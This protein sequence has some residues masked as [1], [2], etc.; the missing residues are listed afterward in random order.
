LKQLDKF[1]NLLSRTQ[2]ARRLGVHPM[3]VYKWVQDASI[4]YLRLRKRLKF[5]PEKIEDWIANGGAMPGK[6]KP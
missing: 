5:D 3:T 1:N 2:V 6:P 4:P